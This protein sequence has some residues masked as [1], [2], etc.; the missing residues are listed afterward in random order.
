[1]QAT[2]KI[3]STREGT[4]AFAAIAALAAVAVLLAF[5]HGYK[6]R[7]D[8]GADPVT[9]LVAKGPLPKGSSGDLI[10]KKGLFQATGFKRDE[11]KQGAITDPASLRGMVASHNIVRGQQLTAADFTRPTD[12]VLSKLGEDQRAVTLPLDS[13]HGMIGEIHAGD[14]VDVYAGFQVQPD[15]AGRP[16]PVLRVLEQDVEVLKA[17]EAG[18]KEGGI[19]GANQTQNIVLRVPGKDAPQLAFSQDNGKVWIAL[20]PQAGAQQGKPSL[21][22]LDRLLLGLDPIPVDQLQSGT[23]DAIKKVYG[24]NS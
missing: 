16:R 14:H 21:V 18:T 15:G 22:T 20:R 1:V 19:G 6:R 5:M 12:P 8:I 11:V 2:R 24:G 23:A 9:V 4:L 13:A 3:L 7:L 17:P 10:A